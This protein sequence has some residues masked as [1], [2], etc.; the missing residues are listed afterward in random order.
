MLLTMPNANSQDETAH[1]PRMVTYSVQI[2]DLYML[3]FY[4]HT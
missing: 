2:T 4:V 3:G 1:V